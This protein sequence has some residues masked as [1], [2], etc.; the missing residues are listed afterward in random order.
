MNAVININGTSFSTGATEVTNGGY[1]PLGTI[2]TK[3]VIFSML[4]KRV[5]V[6][7]ATSLKEMELKA[8]L[9][10][11]WCEEN[12]YEENEKGQDVFNHKSLAS[13]II[14]DCQ[15][16]GPY[17]STQERRTGVWKMADG[18]LVI[19]SDTLWRPDG[20]TLTHG[21]IDN[22]VY[23]V[24]VNIG[25][26]AGTLVASD[27][28]VQRVLQSFRSLK[29]TTPMAGEMLL[30]WFGVAVL[31]SAVK[32]RPHVLLTG[33]AGC[34]KS[35][36][37]E[38]VRWLLGSLASSCT[39]GQTLMGLN[40]LVQEQPAK[41]IVIDEFE[42]D[43]R[44]DKCKQT[45][46]AARSSYSL[47]EG[48]EGIVRGTPGGQAKCYRLSS[49]F[50]AAGISPGKMEPA[51]RTRWTILESQKLESGTDSAE[52]LMTEEEATVLGKSL[53]RLMVQRWE[54][55]QGT[56]RQMRASV[57]AAGGDGRI[58]D[59]MG[60]L[61]AAYWSLTN[62]FVASPRDASALIE[63]AGLQARIEAHEVSDE[64]E[65]LEALLTKVV[66]FRMNVGRHIVSRN[67]SVAEAIRSVADDPTG[68]FELV[69]RLAQL[70]MRVTFNGG[71][72]RLFIV[73]SPTHSELRRLFSGTKWAH[74]GWAL[75][76]RRL[77]GGLES[78]QRIGAGASATK[79]TVI[80]LPE[81]MCPAAN[82]D[83]MLLAA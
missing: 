45:F 83:E 71:K 82:D 61:L 38:Q 27:D 43:P 23:P 75:L 50:I 67:L 26:D 17:S 4:H 16:M 11:D 52:A 12:W 59:T 77:P 31:A 74:G 15:A 58:A 21:I 41:A 25:F 8:L 64:K 36:M 57:V 78:T 76:L 14:S 79:V 49:P 9:G 18:Q 35:T 10:A 2:G 46:E 19:N 5:H 62:A 69:N 80:D 20:S 51:D 6:Q 32:R 72:W 53:A 60:T 24:S 39:G 44:N 48:D 47:Q 56:C 22:H 34:G 3:V 37:L 29:W 13:N 30:G 66:P 7:A 70:G 68:Q 1:I 40:Q 54:I 73:N 65:C 63:A 42:A 28:Q 33:P 55:F 81:A